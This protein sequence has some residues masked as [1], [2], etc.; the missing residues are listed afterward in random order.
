MKSISVATVSQNPSIY[1]C[2]LEN[3]VIAFH[4][5]DQEYV[6]FAATAACIWRF[7]VIPRTIDEVIDYLCDQYDVA[8]DVCRSEAE[9]FV[10]SLMSAGFLNGNAP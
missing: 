10:A 8:R 5:V 7:L 6:R 3:D 2:N 4:P 9:I 1:S